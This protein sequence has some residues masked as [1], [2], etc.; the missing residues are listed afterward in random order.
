MVMGDFR[1]ERNDDPRWPARRVQGPADWRIT[2]LGLV[3]VAVLAVVAFDW[4]FNVSPVYSV[5]AL[6]ARLAGDPRPWL[7]RRLLVRG[8]AIVVACPT[9][10]G[11][12][13]LC[14]PPWGYLTDPGPSLAVEPLPL[15]WAGTDPLLTA[16]RRL[17]LVAD[18]IPPPQVV[19]WEQVAVYRVQLRAAAIGLCGMP[20]CYEV[21]LL[22]AAP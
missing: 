7:G 10:P 13:V 11:T 19:H 6:R 5:A 16:V 1:R 12:P 15:E 22:D 20:P 18:F 2:A 21:V 3:L 8:E 9:D 17:P 14:P 4:S